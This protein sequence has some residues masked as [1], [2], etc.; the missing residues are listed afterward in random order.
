M[1]LRQV[2]KIMP[3]SLLFIA[4]GLFILAGCGS[5]TSSN[6]STSTASATATACAQ[7]TKATSAFRTTTGTLKSINGQTLVVT[8]QQGKDTTVTYSS[9]TTFTQ[10]STIPVTNL[11]EGTAVRVAV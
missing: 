1:H 7:A 8:N 5:N 10:E 4:L 6:T 11:Q 3:M 2:S 9:S